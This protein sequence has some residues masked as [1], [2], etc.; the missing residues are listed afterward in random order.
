MHKGRWPS[1]DGSRNW[2]SVAESPGMAG[3][4]G[5]HQKLE[6]AKKDSPLEPSEGARPCQ[7]LDFR[8]LASRIVTK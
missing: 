8:F 7:H 5:S 4:A 1:G 6:E 3:N 2:N